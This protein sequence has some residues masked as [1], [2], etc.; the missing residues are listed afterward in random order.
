M[1]NARPILLFVV[2]DPYFSHLIGCRWLSAPWRKATASILAV[3][4]AVPR[5]SRTAAER[6]VALAPPRRPGRGVTK[7]RHI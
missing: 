6:F 5:E 1:R 7:F 2:N 4:E 3:P